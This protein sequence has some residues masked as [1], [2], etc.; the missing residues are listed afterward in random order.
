MRYIKLT[1]VMFI[2]KKNNTSSIS[3]VIPVK[4][5]ENKIK[6]CLQAVFNQTLPPLEV[7]VVDGHSSDRTTE[8]ASKFP[9]RVIFENYGTVGG[10][11]QVGLENAVGEYVAFTDADCIPERCWLSNLVKEFKAGIVCVGGGIKNIGDG[12]W[13]KSIALALDSFLGSANSVQD[14]VFEERRFVKSMS[15]CNSIYRRNDLIKIGGFNT[16]LLTNEDT[17]IC[18]RIRKLGMLLY[19]PKAL[20]LHDQN[21][22]LKGFIKR[23]YM[24]G[25]GRGKIRIFDLQVIPP[26]IGL[27][28]LLLLIVSFEAFL[29]MLSIYAI[30]LI[31]FD[32]ML[33]LKNRKAILLISIPIVY[34]IE[35]V[36]YSLGFWK[37]IISSMKK[38]SQ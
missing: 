1:R 34:I 27:A 36:T 37:G 10:A 23:M 17:D 16:S 11:R 33:F 12:L 20:V 22:N 30:I 2:A 31:F 35:H 4:D 8:I 32:I 15:G 18:R 28:V 6:K 29:F 14:R 21:R 5:G 38:D 26:V 25:Y 9:V 13:A 24:F 7:I 19:V 3:I